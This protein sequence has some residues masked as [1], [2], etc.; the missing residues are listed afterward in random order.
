MRN[1]AYELVQARASIVLRRDAD[2][3]EV[4]QGLNQAI[5]AHVSPWSDAGCCPGFGWRV[6]GDDIEDCLRGVREV[7]A[8]SG[9]SLI[10]VWAETAEGPETLYGF[11]DTAAQASG[12]RV[13]AVA[14]EAMAPWSLALPVE[15]HLIQ[16][17]RAG[18]RID[19][20]RTGIAGLVDLTAVGGTIG[21]DDAGVA[22]GRTFV[23]A[24]AATSNEPAPDG[25]EPS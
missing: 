7:E 16:I 3:G 8:V 4:L 6:R 14:V 13:A 20:I 2:L 17:R 1:A 19:P 12:A 15:Q 18:E 25:S 11:E 21:G 22:L 24:A 5:V 9:V 23:I 10:H